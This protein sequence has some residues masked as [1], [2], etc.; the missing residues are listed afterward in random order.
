[1][2]D[3]ETD[4]SL[5]VVVQVTDSKVADHSQDTA[6]DDTITVTIELVNVD[7]PG[8]V[9]LSMMQP[10]VG[11]SITATLNDHDGGVTGTSW[12]WEKSTDGAT[13]W[14]TISNSESG[15]YMPD[16]DDE[17]MYL[18]AMVGYTDG[19]GSG[20]TADGKTG[21]TVKSSTLD[22][23]LASLLLSGIPFTFSSETV[24]YNLTAP[25]SR[26]LTEVM[27]TATATSGV[28]VEITP[29]DSK[30]NRGGHQVKLAVGETRITVTVSED[31]GVGTTTYTLLVTREPA[32][33]EESPQEDSSQEDPQQQQDP[34]Q[35]DPPP[36]ES[37]ADKCRN[38][39]RDGLISNCEVGSF[40]VVRVELDGRFTI[41]WS[42]WDAGHPEVTGYGIALNEM[43][44]KVYY[45]E[46]GQ[47]SDDALADVYES[48]EFAEGEW[49]C[50][51]RPGSNYYE[52]WDGNPTQPLELA[53]NEDRTEWT[54]ELDNPGRHVSDKDFVRWNGDATDPDNQPEDISYKVKVFEMD[55]YLFSIYEGSWISGRETVVIN[56]AN[57]F[58]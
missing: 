5:E 27:L 42:E 52:G 13:N 8:K 34:A 20:K 36:V 25:H 53:S 39:V 2:L 32:P 12:Y 50:Q 48:C 18:R 51:G 56:G 40:A 58:N 26:K 37:V 44:Y 14:E 49:T 45:D 3:Y 6:I 55:F 54:S 7:E 19:E 46:N 43:L 38:D 10:V 57:G 33:Q 41:D 17:E 9:A 47:V 15:S 29:A 23:S 11:K 31:Q 21:D 1:M 24:N 4:P 16:T 28:S 35:Q 22:T 30:P